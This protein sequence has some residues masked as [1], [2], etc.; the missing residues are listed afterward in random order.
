MR[1]PLIAIIAAFLFC[2]L[3]AKDSDDSTQIATVTQR[4]DFIY[5]YNSKGSQLC[6]LSAG[7][8]LTGYTQSSI[9]IKRGGFIYTYNAKGNQKTVIS[10]GK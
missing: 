4:G 10:T 1:L 9:S 5:A 7:D 6:T 2:N 3:S 8:G